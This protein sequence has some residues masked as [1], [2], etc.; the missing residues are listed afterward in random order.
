[1]RGIHVLVLALL[2]IIGYVSAAPPRLE[3]LEAEEEAILAAESQRAFDPEEDEDTT[4]LNK[5]P[6]APDSDVPSI[7]SESKVVF[8]YS[9]D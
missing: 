6:I 2:V 4:V 7:Y 3:D 5:D 9:P 1:M 8:I